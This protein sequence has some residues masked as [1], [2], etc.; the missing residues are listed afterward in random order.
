MFH[1][2]MASN[3]PNHHPHGNSS[4]S[5]NR[6]NV[7]GNRHHDGQPPPPIPPIPPTSSYSLNDKAE[8][9]TSS[10]F[11]SGTA[12]TGIG[13]DNNT[14]IANKYNSNIQI[15]SNNDSYNN[16]R[17]LE[18]QSN[19]DNNNQQIYQQQ[20]QQQHQL[21]S[22]KRPNPKRIYQR[23]ESAE[24][25]LAA[26][27]KAEEIGSTDPIKYQQH[28]QNQQQLERY[29]QQEQEQEQEHSSKG[30]Q[31]QKKRS[32]ELPQEQQEQKQD[33]DATK[34]YA[35][36]V[37]SK[38]ASIVTP[39][40]APLP[41]GPFLNNVSDPYSNLNAYPDHGSSERSRMMLTEKNSSSTTSAKATA[42]TASPPPPPSSDSK[43]GR[44]S[45]V[46]LDYSTVPDTVGFVR[47]KTGGVTKPFPEKLYEMLSIESCSQTDVTIIVSWLPHG[48]AFI[49]R[50][51][52]QF[53][54]LIMPKYF[55]QTKLTSFQRQLN[56]YGFRRITQGSD[57]GAY[58][59]ELFL[60][61]RP[62][63]CMR[64]VRQKVKGTGHKQPTDV[65]TEPNFYNMPSIQYPPSVPDPTAAASVENNA[66]NPIP[67][68]VGSF[69][70]QQSQSSLQQQQRQPNLNSTLPTTYNNRTRAV[71]GGGD[72]I[73]MSPGIHAAHL[74]KGMATAPVFQS[75]PALPF[76]MD[77]VTNNPSQIRMTSLHDRSQNAMGNFKGTEVTE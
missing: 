67:R 54:T 10:G 38:S 12:G 2:I 59:H 62:Q 73:P 74:L 63:L 77:P 28:I 68:Q 42:T 76:P 35:Q 41:S 60:R 18:I 23:R 31:A 25:F 9:T 47:K 55:R 14:I 30:D 51:P 70:E 57:S 39:P 1:K 64:M 48:R 19:Y 5:R 44:I 21:P 72:S 8:E 50:K 49:V 37:P 71:E 16:Y 29:R 56:L 66:T 17:N 22:A 52:K 11:E 32:E 13:N 36:N 33:Q 26:A 61:G 40:S 58:Y 34:A 69:G 43:T 6:T 46:Y 15:M 4:F 65:T 20:Q 75:I 7:P 3:I 27:A 53:T 24:L 45:H